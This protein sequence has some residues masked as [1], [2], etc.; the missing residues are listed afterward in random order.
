[1]RIPG[2]VGGT[3]QMNAKTFDVQRCINLYP[4]ASETGTSKSVGALISCPGYSLFTTAGTGPIRGAKTSANGRAFVVSGNTLYEIAEDGTAT[5]RGTLNTSIARVSI[6]ENKTQMMIVDGTYG[7]IFTYA[8][9]G[10]AQIVDV[11]FPA[12]EIV[13]YLDGYF[14]VPKINTND[15]Y[16][17]AINDGTSWDALDF[18]NAA[19]GPDNLVS[20]ISDSG[21]LWLFGAQ[22]TEIF[23]NTGNALFPFERIQGAIIQTGC[24]APHTV[25]AFDNTIAWLGVDEQGR[26]VVWKAS[27]YQAQRMSNQAIEAVI[28]TAS[29]FADSYAYVY[30]E[31]GHV[32]Y[33]LQINN[34]D[35]TLVY[36]GATGLWHERQYFDN[37]L[38]QATK[39][40]GACHFFF[41]QKNLIGD[42]ESGKIYEQKLTIY[43]HNGDEMHR[44]RITPHVHNERQNIA[45]SNFELDCETG[46]GLQTGQGSDPQV[47]MQYSDDGGRAWSN[48]RWTSLGA[49]GKYKTRVRWSR[50]GSS[51][52]R[53]WKVRYTEP[54][55]FQIN[56]AY[57]NVP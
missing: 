38:N 23:N 1:M 28:A 24:A 27:G 31:Q 3:Y 35:T 22:T 13:T 44:E 19:A 30:H 29:D 9:D 18:S 53:V 5:S 40:R 41:N 55:Q 7:Y 46:V 39:H 11:D 54:T 47:M 2:F 43:S 10:F 20:L 33:C 32:F 51:R 36:D 25:Q 6:A 42:R 21:N 56:E 14:I 16:I 26:G 52:D 48:E 49:A 45:F 17:S 8:T 34:L 12:C 37:S 4:M 15:F 50:C 57:F